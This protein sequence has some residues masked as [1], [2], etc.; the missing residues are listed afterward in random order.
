[1]V[2]LRL[3]S[4]I[5]LSIFS[6][7]SFSQRYADCVK[8]KEICK[9]GTHEFLKASGEGRDQFESFPTPCFEN[10]DVRGNA[11]MNS[12][13]IRFKIAKSG[14]LKFTIRPKKYDD[15]LDFV[16]YK[17]PDGACSSKRIV[18]CMAAGDKVYP[19]FCMGATGLRDDEKDISEDAGCN[20]DKN[21]YLK[22]L[23]VKEGE[24][25]VL[26]VSNVTTEGEG[27][28]IRF[29]GSCML[30][31]DEEKKPENPVNK[32]AKQ[33]E[34]ENSV[35]AAPE[36]PVAPPPVQKPEKPVETRSETE[37]TQSSAPAEIEGRKTVV[38]KTIGV[39][40]R[41]ITLKVW[42][43]SVEDG[44]IISIYINGVN[45]YPNI[46][47]TTRPQEFVL[48]LDRGENFITAHVESFGKREPNTAA[49]SVND[50]KKTQKLTL[51]A[52]RNQEETMKVMVE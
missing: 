1:M 6:F 42:D 11:E 10:G 31:C 4:T 2:V 40:S 5:C 51:S 21:G 23:N 16:V 22:P 36:K 50:G 45:R 30:P 7:A 18:R 25:Y 3:I 34:P 12:V 29:Y 39:S 20:G 27:F 46:L 52:T 43:N 19:S 24:E 9:K 26:L 41:K 44:D 28:S 33:T 17:L 49:I 47:L 48:D 37:L 13:W 15:D 38:N 35:A 8:A 14:S 32:D